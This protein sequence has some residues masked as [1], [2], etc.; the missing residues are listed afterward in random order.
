M[1]RQNFIDMVASVDCVE[2]LIKQRKLAL[3][4]TDSLVAERIA[5]SLNQPAAVEFINRTSFIEK[6]EGPFYKSYIG[7]NFIGNIIT[8][9]K[10]YFTWYRELSETE[11]KTLFPFGDYR[12]FYRLY[13][14]RAGR[15]YDILEGGSG[16]TFTLKLD[17][18][19]NPIC[20]FY[21]KVNVDEN[22]PFGQLHES[23]CYLN[24]FGSLSSWPKYKTIY[25]G[26]PEQDSRIDRRHLYY[27][28]DPS[29]KKILADTFD[30]PYIMRIPN[31]EF[32]VGDEGIS[33]SEIQRP[34]YRKAVFL[35]DYSRIVQECSNHSSWGNLAMYVDWAQQVHG[36]TAYCPAVYKNDPRR[37]IY[38][39]DTRCFSDT[40]RIPTIENFIEGE[41]KL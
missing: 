34:C 30:E 36:W 21:Y 16:Y 3:Q 1:K 39:L 35:G 22:D 24:R 33:Q 18:Q 27:I 11:I 40:K 25:A 12:E 23:Q 37:S 10:L 28:T 6:G 32:C 13:H 41:R 26:W 9:V 14:Q 19:E 29:Y 8:D 4:R 5:S 31:I 2:H 20:G 7:I 38:F 17:L 15:L